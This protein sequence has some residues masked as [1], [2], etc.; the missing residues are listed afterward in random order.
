MKHG[1]EFAG[2]EVARVGEEAACE[3]LER[4]RAHALGESQRV[5]GVGGAHPVV[6][7]IRGGEVDVEQ[8]EGAVGVD[9]RQV[10]QTERGAAGDER[11]E[12][13]RRPRR[14]L[15]ER[16]L[17]TVRVTQRVV[18]DGPQTFEARVDAAQQRAQ[19]VVLAEERVK[20]AAHRRSIVRGA[21]R[22]SARGRHVD[23]P[24]AHS[25][26]EAAFCLD[27]RDAHAALGQPDG[28]A[29]AGN[30]TTHDDDVGGRGV[31][32]PRRSRATPTVRLMPFGR[33]ITSGAP[34]RHPS[35]PRREG[36][37]RRA[38][39]AFS[40]RR[41][42]WCSHSRIVSVTIEKPNPKSSIGM[43]HGKRMPRN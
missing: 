37:D 14:D 2:G 43:S 27:E 28:G 34:R 12:V 17:R 6:A 40:F 22:V 3:H 30:P 39:R 33:R 35:Q 41:R 16:I 29:D 18:R 25:A 10:A 4:E 24:A 11:Q 32:H 31:R 20:P 8:V 7:R 38:H 23:G 1:D 5:E 42:P 36:L 19:V 26:T 9:A 21:R 15:R 13:E